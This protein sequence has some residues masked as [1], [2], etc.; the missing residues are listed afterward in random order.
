KSCPQV[1]LDNDNYNSAEDETF[2]VIQDIKN[3]LLDCQNGENQKQV[4]KE[5]EKEK[6]SSQN[7]ESCNWRQMLLNYELGNERDSDLEVYNPDDTE[8]ESEGSEEILLDDE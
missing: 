5:L 3:N 6:V 7:G 2:D 8:N 1:E 4:S